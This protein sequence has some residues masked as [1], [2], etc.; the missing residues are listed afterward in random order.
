MDNDNIDVGMLRFKLG[1]TQNELARLLDVE[2]VTVSR[3]ERK[4]RKPQPVHFRK[5]ARLM[6]KGEAN[7]NGEDT[8]NSSR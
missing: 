4:V 2:P 3:W 6:K 5:M 8:V 7:D 1:L